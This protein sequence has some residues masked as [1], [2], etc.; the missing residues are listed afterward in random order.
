M[1]ASLEPVKLGSLSLTSRLILGTGGAP[2]NQVIKEIITASNSQLV[3]VALRRY[4][5]RAAN[6]LYDLLRTLKVNILPNTAGC[7]TAREAVLTA[8]MGREALETNNV[9]LE[10]LASD[11]DLLPDPY[12]LLDATEMLAMD[13]F[14]VFA[15]TSD[16]PVV[17]RRLEQAGAQVVMPLGAPIG[18]GLG[19]R[20]AHNIEMIVSQAAVPV[21]LDAGIG[22]AS[23]AA[24]A[25]ELGCDAVLVASAI[26][27]AKQPERMARAIALGTEAGFLSRKGGRIPKREWALA[28]SPSEGLAEFHEH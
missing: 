7:F 16:D 27:R 19:I 14:N 6:S 9:K 28:S 8:K 21:V 24:I 2:S 3:T 25:M 17:A 11:K 13:G 22:T 18:T 23:D 1:E 20:N 10:V 5:P 12:E 4:E 26:T 15:Y